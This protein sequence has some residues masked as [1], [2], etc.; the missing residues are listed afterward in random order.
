M[1]SLCVLTC[2]RD[3]DGLPLR[4]AAPPQGGGRLPR[5]LGTPS[6]RGKE[7][8]GEEKTMWMSEYSEGICIFAVGII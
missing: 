1:S 4:C 6:E 8:K 7:G 3:Y 2:Y 5:P